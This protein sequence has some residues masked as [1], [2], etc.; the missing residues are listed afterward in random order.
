MYDG[1][2]SLAV[3]DFNEDH[4][5][6][7]IA[8][9]SGTNSLGLLLGKGN[10]GFANPIGILAGS[11]PI[12]VRAVDFN[13][14]KHLDLAVLNEGTHDVSIFLGDGHGHFTLHGS[15]DAGNSPVGLAIVDVNGDKKLD[16]MIGN[17][18]GDVTNLLGNGDGTFKPF[19]R[20]NRNMAIAV[21]DLNGDGKQDWVVTNS[22]S[23][24]VSVQ[25]DQTSAF[26]RTD[27]VAAPASVKLAD[28]DGDSIADMIVANSGGNNVLVYRGLGGGQFAAAKAFSAGSNPVEVQIADIGGVDANGHFIGPD[29]KLD[30]IVTNY[31]SNDISILLNTGDISNGGAKLLTPGV[32]LNVGQ[33]PVSTQVIQQ[34]GQANPSLLVTNSVS[35]QVMM[36]N[37]LGNGFFNDVTPILFN[38]GRGPTQT[39]VGNFDGHG[40][41]FVTLNYNSNSLTFYSSFDPASRH[42]MSSGGENPLTAIAADMNSDGITDLVVGNNGNGAFAAF[43]GGETGL[44]LLNSFISDSVDHPA[45]LALAQIGQGQEL[46]LLALD[47]GDELVHVFTRD[48]LEGKSNT[49]LLTALAQDSSSAISGLFGANSSGLG[50]FVSLVAALGVSVEGFLQ[51]AGD[52]RGV[53]GGAEANRAFSEFFEHLGEAVDHSKHWFE[54]TIK[55][56][57]GAVGVEIDDQALVKAVEDIFSILFPHVPLQAVPALFHGVLSGS[58]RAKSVSPTSLDQAHESHDSEPWTSNISE[59]LNAVAETSS[60]LPNQHQLPALPAPDSQR[61]D[62]AELAIAGS[63]ETKVAAVSGAKADRLLSASH[64]NILE[65]W[66]PSARRT[67]REYNVNH[68]ISPN[69]R[70]LTALATVMASIGA[71]GYVYRLRRRRENA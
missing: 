39:L 31:G 30:V 2:T 27:G 4:V 34:P 10:G 58:D 15:F 28:L 1:A 5:L 16:L 52:T 6:D 33:G 49:G 45:A 13:G 65:S 70:R 19:T 55:G 54:S 51:D 14:D 69:H 46:Q 24:R 47:E 26:G 37:G 22:T 9:Q 53:G 44:S 60:Q 67:D 8:A 32:R 38:T 61:S 62:A 23:D 11:K 59:V 25:S 20:I 12:A 64:Q 71:G 36:L 48:S 68:D 57:T 35:N 41:G 29:G 42:D 50:I 7:V 17:E 43:N 66:S 63:G 40:L 56:I 18:L 3:G 21:G